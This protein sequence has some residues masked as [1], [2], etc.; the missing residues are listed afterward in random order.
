[1]TIY[2]FIYKCALN[3]YELRILYIGRAYHYPPDFAFYI[4]FFNKYKYWV[5]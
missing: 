1:M 3:L 2:R 5:F 4:Y